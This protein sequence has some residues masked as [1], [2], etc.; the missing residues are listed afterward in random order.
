MCGTAFKK[1]LCIPAHPL[2]YN[3]R[4]FTDFITFLYLNYHTY[5][6][7]RSAITT[8][9][10]LYAR[11]YRSE[12]Y[13]ISKRNARTVSFSV[14]HSEELN[15]PEDVHDD[16]EYNETYVLLKK[17][18]SLLNERS[19]N[20]IIDS[21]F[22]D[23]TSAELCTKYGISRQRISDLIRK[24]IKRLRQILNPTNHEPIQ[25]IDCNRNKHNAR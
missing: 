8:W 22:H 14:L 21:F 1:I 15:I 7:S 2:Y 10:Y 6:P 25:R 13:R 24:A 9:I 3:E 17:G 16:P 4:H 5:D 12:C 11:A 18:L 19:R 23:Y 20:I